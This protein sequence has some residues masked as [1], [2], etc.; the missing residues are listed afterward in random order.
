MNKIYRIASKSDLKHYLI[1]DKKALGRKSKRP[2]ANDFIWRFQISLRHLEYYTNVKSLSPLHK[3]KNRIWYV[4]YLINSII[5][6]FEIPINVFGKGLSIAH[7]GTIIVNGNAKVGEN[8]RMHT[9]VN[10]GTAPGA[11]GLAPIIGNDV[12]IG[13]GAKLWGGIKIGN[14]VMIGANACVGKDFPDNV[15]IA[16]TPAKI[17]KNIGR[18]EIEQTNRQKEIDINNKYED[19]SSNNITTNRRS[20]ETY[21]RSMSFTKRQRS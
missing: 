16:G 21:I 7:K 20:R 3:I 9:C 13:P 5:C 15:C 12:Y 18:E 17:I 14:N 8:C 6:G 11:F 2:R 1:A 10:I 19:T 4:R